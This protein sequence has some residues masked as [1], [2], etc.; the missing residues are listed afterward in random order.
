MS[1][2]PDKYHGTKEYLLVYS[3]LISAA[4]H[5]GTITYKE[6]AKIMGLP[7]SGQD[8]GQKTGHL[9]G[10]IPRKSSAMADQCCQRSP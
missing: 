10:E 4:Q 3:L 5:R 9:L 6:V 2:T 7:L 1:K 8:M